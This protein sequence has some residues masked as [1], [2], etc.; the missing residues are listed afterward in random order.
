GI[1]RDDPGRL[2]D[3][4]GGGGAAGRPRHRGRAAGDAGVGPRPAGPDAVRRSG[5]VHR[6]ADAS[7]GGTGCGGAAHVDPG[8]GAAGGP[9]ARPS[10]GTVVV[11]GSGEFL[12]RAVAAAAFAGAQVRSLG[13]ELG[14]GLSQAACAYALAALVV[15]E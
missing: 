15:G 5:D 2:P 6:G 9:R 10:P 7:G 8:R 1:L 13:E 14:P 11:S 12:A 3:S 4:W